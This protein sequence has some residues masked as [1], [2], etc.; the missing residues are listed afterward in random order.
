MY[1]PRALV[2]SEKQWD[3]LVQAAADA[4][5]SP[6]PSPPWGLPQST[7]GP[8]LAA[9]PH[10]EDA[11]PCQVL[12]FGEALLTFKYDP[13]ASVPGGGDTATACLRAVGGSE[14]NVAVA[15]SRIGVR[16]AWASVLPTG[17]LGD[18]VI[19]V[20]DG[21]GVDTSHVIRHAGDIGTLHLRR[22]E[23]APLYQRSRSVRLASQPSI[24]GAG[25]EMRRRRGAWR[26]QGRR[27]RTARFLVSLPA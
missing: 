25:K 13:S 11:K 22:G 8:S 26:H 20:A 1:K 27:C 14:L 18:D 7:T 16:S 15:L 19:E 3:R 6:P 2:G 5:A 24:P 17:G 23:Q 10:P 12:C 9:R 21:A 4:P